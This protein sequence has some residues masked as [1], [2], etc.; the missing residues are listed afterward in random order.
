M[1]LVQTPAQLYVM[2]FLLGVAEAGFT[3][4]IIFY[5]NCWYSRSGRTRAMLLFYIGAALASVIGLPLS[6]SLLNLH[7]MLGVL[8]DG[9]TARLFAVETGARRAARGDTRS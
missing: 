8:A 2:R 1:S 5:L 4:G 3:P 6:D 9:G 7:G